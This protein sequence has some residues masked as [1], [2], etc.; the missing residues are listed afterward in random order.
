MRLAFAGC[1]FDSGT[2]QVTGRGGRVI[3]IS[4]KAFQLLEALI[5]ARPRAVSKESLHA[6][7]WPGTFVAD[8]NLPN[9]V[10]DLRAGLGDDAKGPHVIRTVQRFGYAFCADAEVA[11]ESRAVGSRRA[12]SC[13][14]LWDGLEVRLEP[15]ENILGRDA[16]AAAWIDDPGVSRR[17]ARILV[18]E[19]G[20]TLHDLGS[21]N[22]TKLRGRRIEAPARLEDRDVIQIGPAKM[23]FRLLRRTG[24][25][26]TAADER[27]GS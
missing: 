23:I 11:R 24:P 18:D 2:R 15:G 25:T 21:K 22:G 27:R 10:A 6:L 20:A 3:P 19:D 13:R 4:P 5:A 16:E 9:L 17:H 7:L 14:L 12:I 26:E 8:A 1:V